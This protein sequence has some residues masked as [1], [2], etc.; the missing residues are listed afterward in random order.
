MTHDTD[1]KGLIERARYKAAA[2]NNLSEAE[3]WWKVADAL[4][5]KQQEIERLRAQFGEHVNRAADDHI[6]AVAHARDEALEEAM[7]V[8]RTLEINPDASSYDRGRFDGVVQYYNA[9]RALG[10]KS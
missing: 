5:A 3:L 8:Q 2:S 4:A 7:A 9:I 6:A 1:T 10:S